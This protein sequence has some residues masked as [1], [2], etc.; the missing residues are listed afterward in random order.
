VSQAELTSVLSVGA[1]SAAVYRFAPA[2]LRLDYTLHNKVGE[3][4]ACRR[5]TCGRKAAFTVC[6]CFAMLFRLCSIVRSCT[7]LHLWF[8]FH[9]QRFSYI[10][11][12][13]RLLLYI[14]TLS[15]F[16][17]FASVPFQALS[18]LGF[19]PFIAFDFII[20]CFLLYHCILLYCLF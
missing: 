18:L 12:L 1:P 13:P 16:Y 6:C 8:I 11:F 4:A 9:L 5:Q 14:P 2:A 7:S 15:F 3:V 10:I 20:L 17:T 19:F